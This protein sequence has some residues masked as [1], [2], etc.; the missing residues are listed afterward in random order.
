MMLNNAF[1]KYLKDTLGEIR[2]KEFVE[3]EDNDYHH[4]MED[5]EKNI[6]TRF[7]G[8]E[9]WDE[10]GK[11]YSKISLGEM[12]IADDP[13]KNIRRGNLIV[14]GYSYQ[15]FLRQ[16]IINSVAGKHSSISST[17]WLPR[18]KIWSPHS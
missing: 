18:S 2:Y 10:D 17:L 8:P 16:N 5:F 14:T 11:R 13:E 3:S 9:E 6:K 15:T 7:N 1:D 12:T 4:A